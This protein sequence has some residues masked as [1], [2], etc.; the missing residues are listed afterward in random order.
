VVFTT[1]QNI[2]NQF[3]FAGYFWLVIFCSQHAR[4]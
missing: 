3:L 2:D 1:C 4:I